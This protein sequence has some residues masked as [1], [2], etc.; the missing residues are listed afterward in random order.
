MA[1]NVSTCTEDRQVRTAWE[2]P[3]DGVRLSYLSTP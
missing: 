1:E 3:P 2:T